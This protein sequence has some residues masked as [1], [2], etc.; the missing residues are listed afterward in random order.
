MAEVELSTGESFTINVG[1]RVMFREYWN[2]DPDSSYKATKMLGR[3]SNYAIGTVMEIHGNV[4]V[5]W[6]NED[7]ITLSD[8]SHENWSP[9]WLRVVGPSL[10]LTDINNI[11]NYLNGR[12]DHGDQHCR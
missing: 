11:E 1:D 5:I 4:R 7:L 2:D 12:H 3:N 9:Q 8:P 10:D 6:D